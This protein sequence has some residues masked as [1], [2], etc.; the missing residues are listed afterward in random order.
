MLIGTLLMAIPPILTLIS[1]HPIIAAITAIIAGLML[2]AYFI[3][4]EIKKGSAEEKLKRAKENAEAAGE[5]AEKA[6]E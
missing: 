3:T 4:S 5:A 1:A 6:S 2:A